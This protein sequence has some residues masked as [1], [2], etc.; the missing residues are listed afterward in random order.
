MNCLNE[1]PWETRLY[2]VF[3]WLRGD[4]RWIS[5]NR[6]RKTFMSFFEKPP[7]FQN[8]DSQNVF[9]LCWRYWLPFSEKKIA[10]NYLGKLLK[11]KTP[12]V[13]NRLWFVEK[14]EKMQCFNIILW[15]NF[16]LVVWMAFCAAD[17][18]VKAAYCIKNTLFIL[19]L[20]SFQNS[21]IAFKDDGLWVMTGSKFNQS[22]NWWH[23]I[24]TTVANHLRL[25]F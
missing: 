20:K 24:N 18:Y 12:F 22:F 15:V 21:T 25:C 19:R 23:C 9:R 7:V 5:V 17:Y 10:G 6:K 13:F 8:I 2:K 4:E 16:M 11:P 14:T 3:C 1:L